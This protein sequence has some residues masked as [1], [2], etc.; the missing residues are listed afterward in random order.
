MPLTVEPTEIPDVKLFRPER[1]GD[2]RGYFQELYHRDRYAALGLD[3]AFVQNNLSHSQRGALRGLHFQ[4]HHPQIKLIQT[5]R[6][7]IFDVAVD[8]RRGSPTFG[9]WVSR[10]LSDRD[11][12]QLLVPGGFAHGFYVLSP[13]ATVLYQCSDVY[14]PEDEVGLIW[15]DP[16]LSIA[17]PLAGT[18]PVLSPRDTRHPR[19]ASIP[20][21]RLPRYRPAG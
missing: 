6:G 16:A 1:F 14:H 11:G 2:N 5:L 4:L 10:V 19:L 17:W 21:D 7:E 3:A 13:E 20:A 18:A 8:L 15:D 12:A 9:R